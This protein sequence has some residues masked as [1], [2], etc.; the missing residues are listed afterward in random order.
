MP[1]FNIDSFRSQF[2]GGARSYLFYFKPIFPAAVGTDTEMATYLVKSTNLPE[3][4]TDEIA[5]AWQGFDYKIAG[6]YTYSDLTVNFN[7]DANAKIQSLFHN[8]ASLIHDPTTN[9]YGNPVDYMVDQQ[10]ELLD[11]NGQPLM[12]YKLYGAWLKN[13]GQATLD[14]TDNNVITFDV[15][16]TYVYHVT[17]NAKYGVMPTFSS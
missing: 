12:K 5:L 2:S 13:I 10:L 3:T 7:C 17:S 15:T 16:F 8:W 9:A 14:Y 1:Q 4:S 11:L 6:K